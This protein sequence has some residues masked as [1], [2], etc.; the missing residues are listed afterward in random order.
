MDLPQPH[1]GT[2]PS[3]L[4][5]YITDP[6]CCI[7]KAA[8]TADFVFNPT[9]GASRCTLSGHDVT[10]DQGLTIGDVFRSKAPLEMITDPYIIFTLRLSGVVIPTDEEWIAVSSEQHKEVGS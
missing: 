3:Y 2:V 5:T 6:P 9:E 4:K 8:V 7:A 10:L 1:S